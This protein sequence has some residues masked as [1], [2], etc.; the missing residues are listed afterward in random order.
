[1]KKVKHRSEMKSDPRQQGEID[2][3]VEPW[4]L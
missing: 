4:S 1:M 3:D 2:M